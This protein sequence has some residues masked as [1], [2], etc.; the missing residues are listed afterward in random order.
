MPHAR[1]SDADR[2]RS[3]QSPESPIGPA[4][5]IEVGRE[6]LHT[7]KK[8][9]FERV[10]V[11]SSRSGAEFSREVVR[12]PGAVVILPVL[13]TPEGPRVVMIRNWRLSLGRA[14]L[15]LPAGTI[16]RGE[17]PEAC[18]P[19]E[20]IEE[21]G[22]QARELRPLTS[23][24]TTPG[25]TDE[26]MHAFL[27]T[28]LSPVGQA[29]EVDENM[30]VEPVPIDG[31]GGVWDLIDR[32]EIADAKTLLTLLWARRRGLLTGGSVV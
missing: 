15:E 21:T 6:T 27:A 22:F 20:L 5:M 8:F 30:T 26:L 23:F 17:A 10:R 31:P 11:R 24:L 16:E 1:E 32:G 4:P 9:S 7:G 18:A 19:R 25:L 29:M 14:I 12:H 28:D 13:E 2:P 3:P